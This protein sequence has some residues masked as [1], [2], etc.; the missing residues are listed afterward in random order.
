MEVQINKNWRITTD[1]YNFILQERKTPGKGAKVGEEIWVNQLYA[2]D[3]E[4][5]LK[6]YLRR[7]Q[8]D[9]SVKDLKD[10]VNKIKEIEKEISEVLEP[11]R[12]LNLD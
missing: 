7:V 6:C 10:L 11:L 5:V 9:E 12:M 3:L 2:A 1:T 4:G 8:K